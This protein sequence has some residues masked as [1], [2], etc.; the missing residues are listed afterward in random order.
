[1][2]FYASVPSN[3]SLVAQFLKQEL[4]SQLEEEAKS[5]FWQGIIVGRRHLKN[6]LEEADCIL[7]GPGMERSAYT[8][9]LSN[10]LLRQYPDKKWV[11]DAGALQMIDPKLLNENCII[12]PHHQ[13]MAILESKDEAFSPKNYL[14]KPLC[15]LKGQID[16][17]FYQ[18]KV[19]EVTGGNAGMTKGGTGD[20][21][22]GLVAALYCQNDALKSA[23]VGSQV[24]KLAGDELYKSVGPYFNA[25]DLVKKIPEILWGKIND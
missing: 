23:I 1:M 4:D 3:N 25:S 15:L 20:V 7:I 17:I 14:A 2:V 18:G 16:Q 13:E 21:L 8:R 9:R 6:Y 19:L 10:H 24:N 5:N 22:A 12:T 11:V